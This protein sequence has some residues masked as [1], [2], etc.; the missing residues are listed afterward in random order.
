MG[1]PEPDSTLQTRERKTKP[2][3]SLGRQPLPVQPLAMQDQKR[4][5]LISEPQNKVNDAALGA[6]RSFPKLLFLQNTSSIIKS[7][8]FGGFQKRENAQVS[9]RVRVGDMSELS[10]KK[11]WTDSIFQCVKDHVRIPGLASTLFQHKV[12]PRSAKS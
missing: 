10:P 5:R 4:G 12:R 1:M 6:G 7:I 8:L 3:I 11:A 9:R 2:S